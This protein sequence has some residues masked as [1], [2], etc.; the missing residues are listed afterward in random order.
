MEKERLKLL[1]EGGDINSKSTALT[2][3]GPSIKEKHEKK[4]KLLSRDAKAKQI[5]IDVG[6]NAAKAAII[7]G[8]TE[9]EMA[10]IKEKIRQSKLG[11]NNP[12]ATGVKC[13]NINT[14]EEYFFNS[15]SEMQKFFNESNHQF[16]SRRCRG[17][18]K[19]LY[20]NEW[21]IAYSD[22]EY[23]EDYTQKARM[24]SQKSLKIGFTDINNKKFY[25]FDS[26]RKAEE[27]LKELGYDIPSRIILSKIAKGER[28]QLEGYKIEFIK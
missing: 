26:I 14:K 18:I 12:N 23:P 10:L 24:T 17:T 1:E 22:S 7:A 13:K 9:E 28:P 2:I 16:C 5:A 4:M 8:K 20:K 19:S 3:R 15:Q 27:G 21:L 6:M 25:S 11:G